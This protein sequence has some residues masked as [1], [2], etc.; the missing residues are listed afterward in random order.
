M[1]SDPFLLINGNSD[2]TC[3][4]RTKRKGARD[5][6]KSTPPLLET[7]KPVSIIN[8]LGGCQQGGPLENA[9]VPAQAT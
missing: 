6:A 4:W 2:K 3:R 7:T 1:L 8:L 5:S 9:R